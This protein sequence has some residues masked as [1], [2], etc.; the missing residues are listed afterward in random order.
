M[1]IR[2]H[3]KGRWSEIVSALVGPEFVEK[4]KGQPCPHG[5]GTD[6][7]RFRDKSEDGSFFCGCSDGSGDGIQLIMCAR[8]CDFRTAC[9]LIEGVIGKCPKDEK[10]KEPRPMTRAESL[11]G[12]TVTTRR[13]RYL[14]AR[15]LEVAPGLEWMKSLEYFDEDGNVVGSWP[16]ML[17]P[18]YRG[19]E[20][21]TYHVTYLDGD[22][23][24][25]IN[26]ARKIMPSNGPIAGGVCRLY[27]FSRTLGVAE[28]IETA[29]AAKQLFGIPVWAALNTSLLESFRP[30]DSVEKLVV[31]GDNDSK[32][33]GQAAAF[34]CAYR[35][36][37]KGVD[38]DV[39]IPGLAVSEVS[40][41]MDWNDWLLSSEKQSA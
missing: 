39:R 1:K 8:N 28:G 35:A 4:R 7:Y 6:R 13:S 34:K 40:K 18:I 14:E 31:F 17:A 16:A 15:G 19:S 22:K 3:C 37:C 23:K 24:A 36:A 26:P 32:F 29:I 33:A 30:P 11:R 41:G 25:P 21:L 20:F 12:H 10:E 2:D 38:V 5:E 27:P 9:E